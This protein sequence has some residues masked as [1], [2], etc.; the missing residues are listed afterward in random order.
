MTDYNAV[1][2]TVMSR[3]QSA[4]EPEQATA[5]IIPQENNN[6]TLLNTIDLAINREGG[7]NA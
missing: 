7:M 1:M 2:N 3:M 4:P 5:Q 6:E